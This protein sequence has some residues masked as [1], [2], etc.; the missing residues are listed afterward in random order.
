MRPIFSLGDVIFVGARRPEKS[1]AYKQQTFLGGTERRPAT[2]REPIT[3]KSNLTR[4]T[5]NLNESA[6]ILTDLGR[7]D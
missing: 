1:L 3:R 6:V 5:N 7:I 4:F 2:L